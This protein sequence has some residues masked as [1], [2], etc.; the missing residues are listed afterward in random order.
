MEPSYHFIIVQLEGTPFPSTPTSMDLVGIRY[1][2][3]DFSKS[4]RKF[5]IDT[6][7]NVPNSSINDG[8][9]GRIEEKSGF[10]VPVVIDV[11]IQSYTKMVRLYSTVSGNAG[12]ILCS[13]DYLYCFTYFGLISGSSIKWNFCAS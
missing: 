12:H 13:V 4:S 11:S 1:F 2:E 5:D 9:N 10:I 7:K 8:R 3:V 6:T